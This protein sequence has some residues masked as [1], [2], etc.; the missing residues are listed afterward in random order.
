[1]IDYGALHYVTDRQL[2]RAKGKNRSADVLDRLPTGERIWL[3]RYIITMT[4]LFIDGDN[5]G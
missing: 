3:R 5:S 1:M 4:E 2:D